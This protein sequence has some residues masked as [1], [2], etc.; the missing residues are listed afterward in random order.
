MPRRAPIGNRDAIE[1]ALTSAQVEALAQACRAA[2]IPRPEWQYVD[3]LN[4]HFSTLAIS[5]V[6]DGLEE[7]GA[8][9]KNARV[10]AAL[11][12][13]LT[14]SAAS[15]S[16]DWRREWRKRRS[17]KAPDKSAAPR[18]HGTELNAP[19]THQPR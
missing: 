17:L 6:A 7:Q 5:N 8:S 18:Y 1:R 13:G 16:D 4:R 11:Q 2:P 9:R 3:H 10:A 14:E 12:L 15:V 19:F